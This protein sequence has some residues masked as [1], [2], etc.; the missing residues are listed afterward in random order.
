VTLI[1]HG[2]T[3]WSATGKHT[4]VTDVPL[5]IDGEEQARGLGRMLAG[6]TFSL[7]LSSPRQR[8]LRTAQL[9]GL[10]VDEMDDDLVEWD[11]GG[12]EGRTTAEISAELGR[13]WTVFADGVI[14]GPTPGETVGEVGL[15]LDRVLDRIR[16]ALPAGDVAVVGH[17]HAL[18]ILTARWLGLPPAAGAMFK[19]GAGSVSRLGTEHD[20]PTIDLWNQPAS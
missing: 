4:G 12:Y 17:G 8:A 14:A 16:L 6:Q 10:A 20:V 9:A 15:R 18:R 1:R 11:Y 3:E 7:V 2:Q 5:T 13:P 19:L